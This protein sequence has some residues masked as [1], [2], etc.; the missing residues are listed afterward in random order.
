LSARLVTTQR[1]LATALS[2]TLAELLKPAFLVR[3]GNALRLELPAV[4][5]LARELREALY[6]TATQLPLPYA[7]L[8]KRWVTNHSTIQPDEQVCGF[9]V[10]C[11]GC[12]IR[13]KS[14]TSDTDVDRDLRRQPAQQTVG[15]ARI[16]CMNNVVISQLITAVATLLGVCVTLAANEIRQRRAEVEA[17][18]IRREQVRR[19]VLVAFL[20]E[21][22]SLLDQISNTLKVHA[23][24]PGIK[25]DS[26]IDEDSAARLSVSLGSL[27]SAMAAVT[28]VTPPFT[29][30]A[31]RRICDMILSVQTKTNTD[32]SL[33]LIDTARQ[34][35]VQFALLAQKA[36]GI[37]WLPSAFAEPP[38]GFATTD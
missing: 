10:L 30:N 27:Q 26:P 37:V 23:R 4:G 12:R 38:N 36:L 18:S 22:W 8:S 14:D 33:Q 17:R 34:E 5:I 31:A 21:A 20:R 35:T 24:D 28:I 19:D 2:L 29:A 7:H 25:P 6:P 9:T 1:R 32:A 3:H 15:F 13:A 16:F 11:T